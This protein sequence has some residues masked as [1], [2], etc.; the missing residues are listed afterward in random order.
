M[1]DA[2]SRGATV[3]TGGGPVDGPGYFFAPT[4]LADVTP[5]TDLLTEEI[6]GPVAPVA[7]FETDEEALAAGQRHRV[8]PDRL[9][10]HP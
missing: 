3:L 7:T 5:G 2:R 6:F 9:P 1:E 10:V 8:R 4:V